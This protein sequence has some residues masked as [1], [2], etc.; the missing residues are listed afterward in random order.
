MVLWATM[1]LLGAC[2]RVA[3]RFEPASLSV[4]STPAGAG[5][6]LDGRD[7][8]EVTPFTFTGLTAAQHT[9]SVSLAEW[10]A[11]PESIP[12]DLRPL[13]DARV[14]FAL[15]QTG[16]RVTSEPPGARIIVDGLDTGRTTPAIVAGLDPG[17]VRLSLALDTWLCVP[18]SVEVTVVEGVVTEVPAGSLRLRSRRTVLLEGF[19]N[20]NC[21]PCPQLTANLLALTERDGYG[22]DR[23]LFLE[24]A[25]S[26]PN[27]V[28]PLYLANQ[29]EN[30]DRYLYY[31]VLGAPAL[32]V[33]GAAQTDPVALEA[34]AAAVGAQW[35]DD[36]GF[37][38]DIAAEP[39]AGAAVPVTVTLTPSR[40]VDLGGHVL[41]VA[42][43]ENIVTFTAPP[44]TNGQ[45]EFHHVFRDRV[46]APR[47]LGT[48][49]AG[50]PA[51]FNETLDRG[52]A[53]PDNVTVI[54]FVQ[55]TADKAVRQAGSTAAA[56]PARSAF[57]GAARTKGHP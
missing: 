43:Y 16:L 8:G 54:A 44:G 23:A 33:D 56:A 40:D 4:E 6:I 10:H 14:S 7:T 24:F 13:D 11:D 22:P 45:S 31:W 3:P 25:V 9:V 52:A 28:D 17:P 38:I 12:I 5:I 15:F 34:A 2:G 47:A 51:V 18:G 1:A 57:A 46:E 39:V 48:L 19:S 27:P 50:E 42:L 55:R 30:A 53:A 29:A 36:P 20:V 37:I 32:Y 26:W 49:V 21:P 41:Y 35:S